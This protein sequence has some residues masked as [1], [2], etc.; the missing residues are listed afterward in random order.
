VLTA[1]GYHLL[2]ERLAD[3]TE[4]RL[5]E[6]RPL[7][8]ERE[9]D[10]RDVALFESLLAE[11]TRLTALLAQADILESPAQVT[12]VAVGVRARVR[13]ADGSLA[14]V[15]PVHPEEAHLDDERI[16]LSSPLGA[17]LLGAVPGD[18]VVV[19]APV[20]S[21]TCTVEQVEGMRKRRSTSRRSR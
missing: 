13:L 19:S 4:R 3:I 8:V 7:L 14:W 16:S 18:Q 17:A 5:P 21:W 9:R 6:L 12:G 20:G 11:Q 2:E 1:E 15:R 10:E